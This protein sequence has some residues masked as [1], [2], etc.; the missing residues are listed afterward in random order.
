MAKVPWEVEYPVPSQVSLS[1]LATLLQ[2]R[3]VH[4]AKESRC[5]GGIQAPEAGSSATL[6]HWMLVSQ[7][8]AHRQCRNVGLKHS[9][10]LSSREGWSRVAQSA[11]VLRSSV[12]SGR[13]AGMLIRHSYGHS[14]A[15]STSDD[16]RVSPKLSRVRHSLPHHTSQSRE[17]W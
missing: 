11:K 2:V 17:H 3:S 6:L 12:W 9:I 14:W 4:Y 7:H 13:K 8:F 1:D 16:A 5:Q 10:Q 15:V